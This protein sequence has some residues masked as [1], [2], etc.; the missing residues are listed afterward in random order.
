MDRDTCLWTASSSRTM[1]GQ[2]VVTF[3]EENRGANGVSI[4]EARRGVGK[5]QH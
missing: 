4:V 5:R 2:D 1:V 3:S